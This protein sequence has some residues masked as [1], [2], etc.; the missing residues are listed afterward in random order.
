MGISSL[1]SVNTEITNN[2]AKAE[3]LSNQFKAVFANKDAD[4]I[5]DMDSSGVSDIHPLEFQ[6]KGIVSLLRN[7]NTKK[8]SGPNGISCWVLKEAAEEIAPFLQFIFNQSLTAGQVPGDWKCAN[9]TPVLKK[10]SKK[11]ASNYRPVSL[12]SVPCK[13][14]EHIIFH[15]IMESLGRTSCT[16]QLPAWIRRGHS[17][18]SQ[19]ITIV[20]HLARN[21]DHGK[22]TD[23]LLLD[24]SKAFDTVPHKR[25]LKKLDHYGIRGQLIKWIESWLCGRTQTVVVNGSQSSP[26]TVTSGVPPG[27]ILSFRTLCWRTISKYKPPGS[28]YL[29]ERFN[30]GFFA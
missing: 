9:V 28:L 18:E 27:T 22:Q 14:L 11:E 12:T 15:Y 20:E 21:L 4:T 30:G 1:N 19:L 13:I 24:F 16:C 3:I 8:A 17:S 2:K 29:E 23:V 10:G 7:I 25:L 26:A 5:P 6:T